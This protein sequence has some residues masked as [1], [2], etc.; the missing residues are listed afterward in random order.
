VPPDGKP[1]LARTLAFYGVEVNEYRQSQ[2]VRCPVHS[3]DR[4]SCSVNLTKGLF[5]CKACGAQGDSFTLIQIKEGLKDFGSVVEFAASK[6][7]VTAPVP[8]GRPRT[9]LSGEPRPARR[10]YRPKTRRRALS[11]REA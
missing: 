10:G 5:S 8:A 9:G 4:A 6:F 11:R 7:G 1:D 2:L 3:E